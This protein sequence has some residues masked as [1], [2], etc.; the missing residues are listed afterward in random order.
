MRGCTTLHHNIG[1]WKGNLGLRLGIPAPG[2]MVRDRS[3]TALHISRVRSVSH[4]YIG[5]FCLQG[6]I[7]DG[8]SSYLMS[9]IKDKAAMLYCDLRPSWFSGHYHIHGFPSIILKITPMGMWVCTEILCHAVVLFEHLC[10]P[11]CRAFWASKWLLLY[12]HCT[13]DAWWL[14]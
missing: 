3:D 7:C 14:L 6:S 5:C 13:W 1:T 10:V 8:D 12:D 9:L 2:Q 4:L 11:C